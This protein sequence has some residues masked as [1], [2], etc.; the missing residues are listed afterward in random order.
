MNME[1]SVLAGFILANRARLPWRQRQLS[2]RSV[3]PGNNHTPKTQEEQKL[4]TLIICRRLFPCH[5]SLNNTRM[6]VIKVH[7][8]LSVCMLLKECEGMFADQL[9]PL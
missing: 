2:A 8:R 9:Q 4:P 6:T 3:K 7:V 5:I 1:G